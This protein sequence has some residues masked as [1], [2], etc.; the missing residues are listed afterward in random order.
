MPRKIPP[1]RYHIAEVSA[2]RA[3]YQGA[4]DIPTV[5]ITFTTDEGQQIA[6]DLNHLLAASLIEQAMASYNAIFPPLKTSRGGFG[7]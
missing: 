7:L 2:S 6:F 1:V 3:I 5:E 4:T